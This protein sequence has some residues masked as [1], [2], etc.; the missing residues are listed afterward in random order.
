V[1]EREEYKMNIELE[2]I[3]KI[4]SL[5]LE[6]FASEDDDHPDYRIIR[7]KEKVV[8]KILDKITTDKDKQKE[9]YDCIIQGSWDM[10]DYSYKPMCDRLRVLGYIIVV[11]ERRKV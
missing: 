3:A 11:P 9:I 4:Q 5:Y 8:N 1:W 6:I 2:D 10:S 7:P